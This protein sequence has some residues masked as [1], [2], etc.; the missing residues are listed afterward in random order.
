MSNTRIKLTDT[1]Q[2]VIINLSEGNPGCLTFLLDLFKND[3]NNA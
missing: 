3:L 2:D 1:V